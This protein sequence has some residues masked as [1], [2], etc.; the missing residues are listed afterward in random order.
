[1]EID[2]SGNTPA[3]RPVARS[4]IT[5]EGLKSK[6]QLRTV[7]K[8]FLQAWEEHLTVLTKDSEESLKTK[9]E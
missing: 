1:M 4:F 2:A 3:P 6:L 8:E 7:A 9:Q 5:E